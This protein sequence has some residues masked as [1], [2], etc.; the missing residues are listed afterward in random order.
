MSD[1]DAFVAA[2]YEECGGGDTI[3]MLG[4]GDHTCQRW[5]LTETLRR[6]LILELSKI[7]Y[8][9]WFQR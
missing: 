7:E 9:K 6:K 5:R 3:I 1:H 8:S 2:A 4:E